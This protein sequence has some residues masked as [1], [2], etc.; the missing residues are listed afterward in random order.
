MEQ[1]PL[2]W[3]DLFSFWTEGQDSVQDVGDM[4]VGINLL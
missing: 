2:L 4:S 3:V 1:R